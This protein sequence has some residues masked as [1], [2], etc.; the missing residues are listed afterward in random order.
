MERCRNANRTNILDNLAYVLGTLQADGSD[1]TLPISCMPFG[2]LEYN[3]AF[4]A[5][6]SRQQVH[7]AHL[8]S[9]RMH[10]NTYT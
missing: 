2:L 5:A 4:F 8:V 1:S 6:A 7:W 3:A 9:L 10:D